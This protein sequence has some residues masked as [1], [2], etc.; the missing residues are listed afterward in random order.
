LNIVLHFFWASLSTE[1]TALGDDLLMLEEVELVFSG[2]S[3][4]GSVTK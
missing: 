3:V 4:L 2:G 1:E